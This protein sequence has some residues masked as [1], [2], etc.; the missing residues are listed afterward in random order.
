MWP[1]VSSTAA[2]V[3]RF[4]SRIR[5]NVPH[6]PLTGVD[7]DGVGPGARG[8][9][10]A[11]ARQH[12]GR[13]PGEQHVTQS[14]IPC[15]RGS[16]RLASAISWHTRCRLD[17]LTA[18][19]EA[20]RGAD[21]RTATCDGQAQTRAAAGT[22]RATGQATPPAASSSDS[23]RS[24]RSWRRSSRLVLTD[25]DKRQVRHQPRRPT[26]SAARPRRPADRTRP[27]GRR[28]AAAV[29]GA[30]RTWAPTASTR[31]R[32]SRP[33]SRSTP[34]ST[35]KVPTDPATGQRQH[36]APTRATSAC[37]W[38]TPRRR[39]PSTA[40]PAWPSRASSTTRPA[41]G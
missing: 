4:S 3:S 36:D 10:V 31:R 21:Q 20:H 27:A 5:R 37:S 15:S 41:T 24:P 39:A 40:S 8:Q 7:D 17:R 33:A 11:V 14:P 9:H 23:W 22:P 38:T 6:R 30:G 34:P 26:T 16:R 12:A 13:E 29:Q 19:Q 2:G 1:C 18:G 25:K 35:G 32:R 28:A